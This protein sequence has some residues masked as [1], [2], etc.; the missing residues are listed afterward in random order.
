MKKEASQSHGVAPDCANPVED[1]GTRK[2]LETD[3]LRRRLS[4]EA[5]L[6]DGATRDELYRAHP[7]VRDSLRVVTKS[8]QESYEVVVQVI[9]HREPG[10]CFIAE[11]RIGK[12]EGMNVLRNELASTFPSLPVGIVIAKDH[13]N[14][15]ERVFYGDL[16][17]DYRHGAAQSGTAADRRRRVLS[18]WE[19]EARS[20]G[21]DRYVLL[22]DEGQ[23]YGEE[24]LTWL[25]DCT[26]DM[27]KAGVVMITII[28]AHPKLRTIRESLIARRRTD[29]IGRF[30]LT[31]RDFRG[32]A[33]I[34]E[35]RHLLSAYD[36]AALHEFPQ[37]SGISMSEFFL[38]AAFDN[39]WRLER[40]AD[41]MWSAFSTISSRSGKKPENLGMQWVTGAVRNFLFAS[42]ELD[43]ALFLGD[44]EKWLYAVEASGYESSL[45]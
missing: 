30:L 13:T 34:V 43:N 20:K 1:A 37:G 42:Y 3:L 6:N 7:V 4:R 26:N 35:L 9:V 44:D 32:I 38:P 17:E 36:N 28:F 18:L 8:I 16:L 14:A 31:P 2:Q 39:G 41:L 10:T 11:F 19:A 45:V 5:A 24:Q 27:K 25:R 29:L 33:N 22:V 21:S 12:T 40:E 23:C 15:S